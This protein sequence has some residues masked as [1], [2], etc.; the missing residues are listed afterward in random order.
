M[1]L[2]GIALLLIA[3]GAASAVVRRL[4]G[5]RNYALVRP[6]P[7]PICAVRLAGGRNYTW[8]EQWRP[9]KAQRPNP[10]SLTTTS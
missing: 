9:Q 7:S 10:S 3:A 6:T 5:R 1:I 8:E 2:A 4:N